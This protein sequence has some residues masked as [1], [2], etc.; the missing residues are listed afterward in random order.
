MSAAGDWQVLES[1]KLVEELT[2]VNHK[3]LRCMNTLYFPHFPKRAG[4]LRRIPGISMQLAAGPCRL[5][6]NILEKDIVRT[7]SC[8]FWKIQFPVFLTT[9]GKQGRH[10]L[11]CVLGALGVREW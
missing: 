5:Q 7:L 1:F 6:L 4:C 3:V 10:F 11:L 9:V 2:F 8:F